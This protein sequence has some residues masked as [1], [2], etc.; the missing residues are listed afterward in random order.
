MKAEEKRMPT[1]LL[2]MVFSWLAVFGGVSTVIFFKL[3]KYK[4]DNFLISSLLVI[5][6][7][8]LLAAILRMFGNIGQM[9]FDSTKNLK[10]LLDENKRAKD[11]L[12]EAI[13]GLG[14]AI[15]N[16]LKVL[17]NNLTISHEESRSA[18]D[19]LNEAIIGLGRAISND[20]KVL[21]NNL[22]ISHE[23]SRSAKDVLN[24]AIIGLGR[25]IS[26]D[27]KVLSNNLTISHEE[28]LKVLNT[29]CEQFGCDLKD[30]SQN[31]FRIK[32]I[33]EQEDIKEVILEL[34]RS[35]SNSLEVL[36]NNLITSHE[37]NL[38]VLNTAYE[39][40]GCDLK[41]MKNSTLQIKIF[42]EQI[43]KHLNL[44]K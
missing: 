29:A 10:V 40:F 14:R 36:S 8:M 35:I 19:V 32:S 20:L 44:K 9:V 4:D 30:L 15:S 37:E 3:A 6:G 42:F 43:E 31:A 24:E 7:S 2:L 12:N 22:T 13:I 23:E 28:N 33:L 1:T 5:L 17:S 41:D 16:D 39:Q 11:V 18:K 21:S 34:Q 38:K 27:L 25:A 26:N